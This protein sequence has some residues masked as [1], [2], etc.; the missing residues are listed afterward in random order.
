MTHHRSD[1]RADRGRGLSRR[2]F[3]GRVSLG[4][5]AAGA[6]W[7]GRPARSAQTEP[8]GGSVRVPLKIGHRAASMKMV[9]NFG[10]F[11]MANRIPGLMGL[12]LQVAH[13]KPNL[14]NMDAVRR[15]KTEANLWGMMIPSLAG[16]WDR[17]VSILKTEPA[18][19]NLHQ[20]I[21]LAEFLGASVVLAAFFRDKAPDM[22]KESS[23][24]P[25][26]EMLQR[27]GPRAAKGA[28]TIGLE[29]SL[30]PAH[31]KKL[32]DLVDH[33]NVKV[34]YDPYNMAYY[35]YEAEAVPGVKLLGKDRICQMHVKNGDKLIEEPGPV[36]WP[37]AF[38]ALNEIGY[39]GWY[40]F[41]SSHKS[42]EQAVEA[43]RKNVAF[44]R[45]HIRMPTA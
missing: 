15:Y 13:G 41:E 1:E 5:L 12:E 8:E 39:D 11:K 37:A 17:G 6:A 24:K 33:P 27:V 38:K 35:G 44:L 7:S 43:T 2:Q 21:E 28:V 16:L 31:N 10:V 25:V 3:A 19:K 29:N 26:V 4:A 34:Y 14:R 32:V 22:T 23:Y 18:E 36:D 40:V 42:R 45:K 9:G 30:S 20:A